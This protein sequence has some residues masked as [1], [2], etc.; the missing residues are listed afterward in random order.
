MRGMRFVGRVSARSTLRQG[1][2][3]GEAEVLRLNPQRR[4]AILKVTGWSELE[5]GTLNL[6]VD[7]YVPHKLL[8][9][10][11]ALVEDGRTVNYPGMYKHI[12][13]LRGR[14]LYYRGI[15]SVPDLDRQWEVLVRRAQN[16]P[17]EGLVE[18][19]AERNLRRDL[20][21]SDGDE[22]T[23]EINEAGTAGVRSRGVPT[24]PREGAAA[25]P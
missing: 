1:G 13:A 16:M 7:V 14:Y 9:L 8:K 25:D 15:A 24:K 18:L 6:E 20:E 10:T 3:P 12:P 17:R 19:F 23:V 22:L 21:L 2:P 5:P 4:E 11:A